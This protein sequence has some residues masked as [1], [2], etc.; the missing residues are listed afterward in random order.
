MA[1]GDSPSN[2]AMLGERQWPGKPLL[3]ASCF[4]NNNNVACGDGFPVQLGNG[5][6]VW[7]GDEDALFSVV[8]FLMFPSVNQSD[9]FWVCLSLSI[10][11]SQ[12]LISNCTHD[13][14]VK[15]RHIINQ[16]VCVSLH[17]NGYNQIVG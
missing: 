16:E 8:K 14:F 3:G 13:Q 5:E 12:S 17:V 6:G 7:G 11:I 10:L 1:S 4:L 2:A 15:S 9:A